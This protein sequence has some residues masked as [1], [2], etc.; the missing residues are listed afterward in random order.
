VIKIRSSRASTTARG[1]QRQTILTVLLLA[2]SSVLLLSGCSSGLNL[3]QAASDAGPSDAIE[4]SGKVHGGQFPVTGSIVSVYEIGATSSTATNYG[5]ALPAALATATTDSNGNF[6]FSAANDNAFTC[7]NG[8]DELYLVANGGNPG[9]TAGTNN[10]ALILTSVAGP[11]NSVFGNGT[12]NIDEVTTVA[13]EFALAGFSTTYQNV[14]TSPTNTTGL[15]NAFATVN[16]MVNLTTGPVSQAASVAFCPSGST[17]S[18]ASG[19]ALCVTPAYATPPANTTPDLFHGI[20]PY[21]TINT[22]ADVLATC[23]NTT[24]GSSSQ[25]SSLFAI[26]GGSMADPVGENG[27]TGPVAI[28]TA[29]A[30]LY[31]AHNPG[32]PAFSNFQNN[33]LT[34]LYD[35]I[36]GQ[37]PFLPILGEAPTADYTLT[38]NF[39][40]GGL[41]GIN[42]KTYTQSSYIAIDAN[43]DVWVPNFHKGGLIELS[44]LGAPISPT[45]TVTLS[46]TYTPILLGGYTGG[47]STVATGLAIDQNGNAWVGDSSNCLTEYIPGTGYNPSAPFTA[48]CGGNSGPLG[49]SVD[50][51]NQVWLMGVTYVSAATNA[52][53]ILSASFPYTS[54]IH[55]LTGFS[56]PDEAGHTFFIDGGNGSYQAFDSNGTYDAGSSTLLASPSN[57]AAFGVDTG[58][59]GCGSTCLSLWIPEGDILQPIN[60]NTFSSVPQSYSPT[61]M[62][63]ASGI[64]VDG[65]DR[66]YIASEPN[67]EGTIPDNVTVLLKSA[68]NAISPYATGYTGG[69][70]L[71]QLD[72]VAGDAVDQSGNV[73]VLNTND[74]LNDSTESS[75]GY[76][77]NGVNS[78]NVTEFVGLANPS[79]PVFSSAAKIGQTS[80]ATAPGAYG[81]AP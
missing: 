3:G 66:V 10:G 12:F 51:S 40:G 29:D 73:W 24:G 43:G 7:A 27:V 31:I 33:N 13:T 53:A 78:S 35:L 70:A 59:G 16:N 74:Y 8:A 58:S 34:N 18:V 36:A 41:G 47:G 79:N 48:V 30:A 71:T 19:N 11:C 60:T 22:L 69:S 72:A 25:C 2:S 15:I 57:Y 5:V 52:G 32:L 64:A 4:L 44:N 67:G 65:A 6:T 81:V 46:G 39:V 14:G 55:S 17:G 68:G 21:D 62:P 28:N 37:T 75:Q 61:T 76:K 38:L 45:T 63:S 50:A 80:G 42:T 23:V 1:A 20:V 54:T 56:G 9:L 49:V 26:T 77:G